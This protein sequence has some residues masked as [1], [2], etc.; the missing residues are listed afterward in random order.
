MTRASAFE[1]ASGRCRGLTLA[2]FRIA[3]MRRDVSHQHRL[4]IDWERRY[5]GQAFYAAPC[6]C[7]CP[8]FNAAYNTASVASHSILFSPAQIGPLPDDK[9]HTIAYKPRLSYGYF[10][11]K[12]RQIDAKT[13]ESLVGSLSRK[14]KDK[15]VRDFKAAAQE[16]R[17]PAGTGR[18]RAREPRS[19]GG[20]RTLPGAVPLSKEQ[21]TLTTPAGAPVCSD[22]LG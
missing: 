12:P 21:T 22:A 15:S 17:Q 2:F 14:F 11:S 10:C 6:L 4:L 8:A 1:I 13:F 5:P 20:T 16:V 9:V 18:G 7:N 19:V 3:L